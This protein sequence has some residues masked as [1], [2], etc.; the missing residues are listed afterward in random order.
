MATPFQ[1][2]VRARFAPSPTGYLHIGGARTALFNY[3]FA[4]QKGGALILR[5]E[6]TDRAR[7]TQ[8][9]IQAIVSGLRYLQLDWD[10]GPEV[11][12]DCGPYLQSERSDLH[13]VDL[14]RLLES[15]QVYPCFCTKERL[16]GLRAEQR[17]K[18]T[19]RMHY[20]RL[21]LKLDQHEVAARVAAEEPH[22]L[23]FRVPEGETVV[24]DLIRGRVVTQNGEIE[25]FVVRR[26]DGTVVYNFAVVSDD[27]GMR[28]NHVIRGEDHLT[29][30][31]KQ[32]LLFSALGFDVPQYTHIPLILGAGGGKLSKRHGAVSVM[33]YAEAGYLPEAMNNF[34]ARMGWSYDDQQE[35]FP[36]AEMIEKFS[37]SGVSK[38]GAMY[39]LKK[40]EHLGGHYMR[41]RAT[42]EVVDLAL[43]YLRKAGF[44]GEPLA[45]DER[46]RV[47][48]MIAL[49][50]ERIHCLSELSDRLKYYFAPSI[51]LEPGGKKVLRKK[52]DSSALIERYA[53]A[54]ENDGSAAEWQID[55][56]S[57]FE[58]HA[59]R[60]TEAEGAKLGD[61]AQP[62]RALVTGRNAS[63]GLFEVLAILGRD[64]VLERL[65]RA[66]ELFKDAN[67]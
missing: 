27:H 63:P 52:K 49:E 15:G 21:C 51:E 45:A 24:D 2:S 17:A 9:A 57:L 55:D 1:S 28:I 60:F 30:T 5:I 66:P 33:E 62:V 67:E 3:L 47:A 16:D 65:R 8:E 53:Q 20:D 26:S 39:D 35:I 32:I 37:F 18:K 10:E 56:A 34:L 29:N 59:R 46:R 40:L 12:G 13:A 11:G 44:I 25:D 41:E 31:P 43:P 19:G 23:R 64:T 54:I 4:R 7:S 6:D 48:A 61:L 14:R 22:V 58:E 50:K 36:M 42:A 38:S